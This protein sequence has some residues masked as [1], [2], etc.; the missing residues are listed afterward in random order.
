MNQAGRTIDVFLV[1]VKTF[2]DMFAGLVRGGAVAGRLL[3]C[4]DLGPF[5]KTP[6]L[7]RVVMEGSFAY[8]FLPVTLFCIKQ[9]AN[10][11]HPIIWINISNIQ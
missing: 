9:I 1:K 5:L 6:G 8:T 4:T 11:N 7:Y 10:A 3:N 2:A